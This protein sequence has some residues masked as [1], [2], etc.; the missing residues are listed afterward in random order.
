VGEQAEDLAAVYRR[1][2]DVCN[3]HRFDLLQDLVH[4]DVVVNGEA[5]GLG[6][7]VEDLQAVVQAFPDYHWDLRHLL[8]DGDRIAA[9]FEDTGT[10]L[11]D[12]FLGVRASGRRVRTQEF[13][14]YRLVTGRI[15]E[16]W[17]TADNLAVVAQL[18]AAESR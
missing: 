16:V 17:V 11:G 5:R 12:P 14:F 7:Y 4:E 6:T 15:A 2:N 8:I 9:H 10:H 18:R 3:D 1:Y 13:A